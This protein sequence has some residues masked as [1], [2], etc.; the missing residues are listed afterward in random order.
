MGIVS[1]HMDDFSLAGSE[2]F[3]NT[4]TEDIREALDISKIEDGQF[5][6]T[7]IDVKQIDDR[8]EISMDDYAASLEDIAVREDK[9]DETLT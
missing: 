1:T 2:D 3:L 8:I 9:S 7:G 6:F 4:V 5:R